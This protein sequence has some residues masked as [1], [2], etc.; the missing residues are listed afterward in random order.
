MFT[1][2]PYKLAESSELEIMTWATAQLIC[3]KI[4]PLS[5]W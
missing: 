1:T 2:E 4:L 3:V 5:S